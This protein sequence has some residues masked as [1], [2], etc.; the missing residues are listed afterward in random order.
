[1]ASLGLLVVTTL[2][3]LV[4]VVRR[5]TSVLISSSPIPLQRSEVHRQAEIPSSSRESGSHSG[6]GLTG[7]SIL[8]SRILVGKHSRMTD[9]S[10][11]VL[12]QE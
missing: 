5:V 11:E 9:L 1:M 8:P 3:L 10:L 7:L 2:G 12:L 4:V 6:P